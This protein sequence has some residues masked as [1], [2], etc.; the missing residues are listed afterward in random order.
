MGSGLTMVL[1]A[2]ESRISEAKQSSTNQALD[3]GAGIGG[4]WF[5][6]KIGFWYVQCNL[7]G[8]QG[9]RNRMTG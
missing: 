7:S 6:C 5:G 1:P 4:P 8:G 3:K 9:H 2:Y